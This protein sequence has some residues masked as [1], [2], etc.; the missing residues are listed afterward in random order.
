MLTEPKETGPQTRGSEWSPWEQEG[1]H[2]V[3]RLQG[4]LILIIIFMSDAVDG[5]GHRLHADGRRGS[6]D[7]SGTVFGRL[8]E[9]EKKWKLLFG[10]TQK[11]V[12]SLIND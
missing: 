12:S 6:L 5:R 9:R 8:L 2:L 7:R 4:L 10:E 3:R 1:L 11:S